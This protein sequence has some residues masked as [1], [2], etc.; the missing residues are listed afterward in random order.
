MLA[1]DITRV[2]GVTN[3]LASE[4]THAHGAKVVPAP[5]MARVHGITIV[6]VSESTHVRGVLVSISTHIHGVMM[7]LAFEILLYTVYLG[8]PIFGTT[9]TS[10]N[11]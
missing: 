11:K 5:E 4:T 3:E 7:V 8:V 2:R 1:S 9:C 10:T 6:F